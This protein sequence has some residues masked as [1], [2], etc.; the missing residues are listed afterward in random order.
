[1][2][3]DTEQQEDFEGFKHSSQKVDTVES[4]CYVKG[5]NTEVAKDLHEDD[6][7][8]WMNCDSEAPVVLPD[9]G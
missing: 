4:I 3:D 7:V 8:E 6:V 1:M 5:M 9:D 2:F